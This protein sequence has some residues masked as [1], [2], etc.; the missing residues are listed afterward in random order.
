MLELVPRPQFTV[1]VPPKLLQEGYLVS[2]P[3]TW[4]STLTALVGKTFRIDAVNQVP[5]TRG[6][7]IPTGDYRDVDLSNGSGTFQESIYPTHSESLF[8]V[9]LGLKPG[10][11][12]VHF[13]IPATRHIHSLEYAEMY[14]LVTSATKVYLGARKPEDSPAEDPRIRFYLVKDLS[15]LILR[16]YVLPGV[17]YEKCVLDFTIN[18]CLLQEIQPTQE[19]TNKAKVLRYYED[20]R[21]AG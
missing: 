13:Y 14:P 2:F 8:E 9:S 10:N 19:Q 20:I 16:V 6:Y 4:P 1:V 3:K 21:W 15:P 7:I 5:Y 12:V 11:Y 18:K 17:D